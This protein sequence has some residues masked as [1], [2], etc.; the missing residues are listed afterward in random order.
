MFHQKILIIR[1]KLAN[2]GHLC[3]Q[4]H[5][6]VLGRGG[7]IFYPRCWK[8]ETEKKERENRCFHRDSREFVRPEKL[9][10]AIYGRSSSL[11]N[12]TGTKQFFIQPCFRGGLIIT[13]ETKL[14][15]VSNKYELALLISFR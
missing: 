3:K 7:G 13:E 14:L 15:D 8:R 2:F 5:G 1:V 9:E 12:R 4:E 6:T 11:I 10:H